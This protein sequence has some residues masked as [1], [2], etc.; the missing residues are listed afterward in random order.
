[1]MYM[2]LSVKFSDISHM[3]TRVLPSTPP[4]SV[5]TAKWFSRLVAPV[6][7]PTAI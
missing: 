4:Q 7:T 2:L 6:C 3:D 5:D 1:M